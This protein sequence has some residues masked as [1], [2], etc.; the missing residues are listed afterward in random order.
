MPP[1]PSRP[2]V[3][4]ADRIGP[5]AAERQR[6]ERTGR[7]HAVA[8][9]PF[10]IVGAV[11]MVLAI[12]S[13]AFALTSASARQTT[14]EN[15]THSGVSSIRIRNDRGSVTLRGDAGRTDVSG[16][17]NV[18]R[19]LGQ[20][21]IREVVTD[22]LLTID[23]SCSHVDLTCGVSYVLDVPDLVAV[24]VESGAGSVRVAGVLGAVRAESGAG[25]VTV[26]GSQ[27]NLDLDAGAGSVTATGLR[28]DRVVAESGAGAVRLAFDA[29]PTLVRAKAGAGSVDVQV[30]LD[31]DPYR[32]TSDG[33]LGGADLAISTSD[34][35]VRLIDVESGAGAVRVHYPG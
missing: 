30:P 1:G 24:D 3:R 28:S 2:P 15:V 34:D 10:V 8:R 6:A 18:T 17:R 22:G 20:P 26:T 23:V 5:R 21:T 29:A 35:A 9:T 32:V 4:L 16:Q 14:V 19:G 25:S 27:G 31:A 13:G 12:G 11:V 7:Y 33:G